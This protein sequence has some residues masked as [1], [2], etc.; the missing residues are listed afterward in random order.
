MP[1][2]GGFVQI[3]IARTLGAQQLLQLNSAAQLHV[4]VISEL[5][6]K[7]HVLIH[8][9]IYAS[10]SRHVHEHYLHRNF[11]KLASIQSLGDFIHVSFRKPAH[12]ACRLSGWPSC[13]HAALCSEWVHSKTAENDS[14][15][16]EQAA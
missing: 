14:A 16:V 7:N 3:R 4:V 15:D 2:H 9:Y 6:A 12:G 5:L 8:I 10:Y 13:I 1:G 11:T